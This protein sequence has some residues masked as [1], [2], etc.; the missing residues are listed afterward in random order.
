MTTTL[1]RLD[2]KV[3][4]SWLGSVPGWPAECRC[5]PSMTARTR[6]AKRWDALAEPFASA[7]SAR[8]AWR[9]PRFS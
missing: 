4:E 1:L 7:R 8:S 2:R 6:S 3:Q 5:P 9:L